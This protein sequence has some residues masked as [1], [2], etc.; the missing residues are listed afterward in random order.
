MQERTRN[1]TEPPCRRLGV[2]LFFSHVKSKCH[3]KLPSGPES[4]ERVPR[5]QFV[6]GG[7]AEEWRNA[8]AE[9]SRGKRHRLMACRHC[10]VIRRVLRSWKQNDVYAYLLG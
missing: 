1:P 5:I 3:V 9:P 10:R 6:Q 7:F 4:A 8:G 2:H